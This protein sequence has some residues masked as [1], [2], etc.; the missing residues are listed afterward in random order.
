MDRGILGSKSPNSQHSL[1][2]FPCE[3]LDR[4]F[5]PEPSES[6]RMSSRT[7]FGTEGFDVKLRPRP[8]VIA[9]AQ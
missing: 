2:D 1:S 8:T 4:D 6:T 7:E 3:T 5:L 9:N